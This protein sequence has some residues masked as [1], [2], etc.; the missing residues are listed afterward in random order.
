MNTYTKRGGR[1]FFI[2]LQFHPELGLKLILQPHTG[3]LPTNLP[4]WEDEW[5]YFIKIIFIVVIVSE[6]TS[7]QK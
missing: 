6:L 4:K 1:I 3:N 7:L 5:H 2:E